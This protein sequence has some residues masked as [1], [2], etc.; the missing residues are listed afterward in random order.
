MPDSLLP[1]QGPASQRERD[2]DALLSGQVGYYVVVSAPV[3]AVVAAL[4]APPVP[5]EFD[6][7]AAARSAFRLFMSN[8]DGAADGAPVPAHLPL[9]PALFRQ[10]ATADAGRRE[11]QGST[12]VLPRGAPGGPRHAR[13]RRLVPWPGRWQVTAAACGAAA[14]SIVCVLALAGAFSG[15]SGQRQ[16]GKLPSLQAS[17]S[18]RH[19]TPSL[20]GSA[21]AGPTP[22]VSP[23]QLCHQ[24][25]DFFTHPESYGNWTAEKGVVQQLS[26]LAGGHTRINGYCAG[27]SGAG[28]HGHHPGFQ[29]GA[30][31]PG[32]GG[33]QGRGGPGES[34]TPRFGRAAG[35]FKAGQTAR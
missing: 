18:S 31:V 35:P 24:Y 26:K 10:E 30:G 9:D 34:D 21:T 4:R 32:P 12:V 15:P 25:T 2:L 22:A 20:L 3:A 19:A 14:A 8:G 13:P 29:G 17:T 23:Q 27:Q 28:G 7:E 33:Q 5:D 16:S 6:G 1:I 11:G